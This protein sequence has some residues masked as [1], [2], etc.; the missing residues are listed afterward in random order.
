MQIEDLF[1]EIKNKK[2][3]L[4]NKFQNIPNNIQTK[5]EEKEQEQKKSEDNEETKDS[6]K[7]KSKKAK[8]KKTNFKSKNEKNNENNEKE[9]LMK[10][11]EDFKEINLKS[12]Y[13]DKDYLINLE[14][15]NDKNANNISDNSYLIKSI[16]NGKEINNISLIT[17][18]NKKYIIA[19]C[20]CFI[21]IY[22]IKGQHQQSIK[23]HE[24]DITNLIQLKDGNLLSSCIDGTMKYFKL[25]KNEGYIILQT[26][27]TTKIK[28]ENPNNIFS[29]NQLYVLLELNKKEN[30]ITAH[31]N[32][33]LIYSKKQ[34]KENYIYEY[35]QT[36]S[37]N[38][39]KKE[40]DYDFI[41]NNK[42]ISSLIEI[43]D[44]ENNI[45]NI[46][47][48]ATNNSSV[49]FIGKEKDNY[50][51]KGELNN[52]CGNGGPNNILYYKNNIILA[53]G[54]IIYF[55][56]IKEKKII[57]E[58]K[59]DCCGINC[60]N[61]NFQKDNNLL[62]IGYENKNNQFI[63]GQYI[64][65]NNKSNEYNI[66]IKKEYKNTHIKRISNIIPVNFDENDKKNENIFNADFMKTEAISGSHDKYIKFWS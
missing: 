18:E 30:I 23:L 22:D 56:D 29:N 40:N 49:F 59:F 27:D 5:K 33:L 7:K 41:I 50:I 3:N 13:F 36:L 26:I 47:F 35:E 66:E 52:L 43:N 9:L 6:T 39:E 8:S 20:Y 57:N 55:I 19:S 11:Y 24:S 61:I 53:G 12:N 62:F 10:K 31:G 51:I 42:N 15:K 48:I 28:N 16:H 32:N 25:K 64:I 1:F 34:E 2:N 44:N 54:N 45:N 21:N 4:S 14:T 63:I 65:N 17:F 37:I 60:I 58:I 38:K 46:Q